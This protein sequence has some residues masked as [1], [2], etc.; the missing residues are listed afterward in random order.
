MAANR[1]FLRRR[2][3]LYLSG[4]A[5][6]L[7]ALF[8]FGCEEQVAPKRPTTPATGSIHITSTPD[9]A[10]VFFDDSDTG[11]V[12]PY[13]ISD[14]SAG[15]H[16]IRLTLS[17]HSDWGPKTVPVAAGQTTTVDATL[18][19]TTP[20]EPPNTRPTFPTP[21]TPQ[22]YTV[23]AAISPLALPQ[24]TGGNGSLSYS[25]M[26]P[27][28]GLSF[29][30]GSRVLSG[31]PTTAGAYAMSYKAT[32]SDGDQAELS[33][34]ITIEPRVERGLG[35]RR[36]DVNAYQS[37]Y[38]LRAPVASLP[39]SIDLTADFPLPRSQGRQASCVGW[40]VAFAVKSYHERVERGW[41]LTDD[42]HIMSPAYIYNQIKLPGGGAYYY[43]AFSLVRAQGVSSW[44]LMPYD[45]R[46]DQTQPSQAARAEAADYKIADWGGV[47]RTTHAEFVSEV[48]RHLV[49]K[50]PVP[51]AIPTC[52]DFDNLD[53]SNPVYD[54]SAGSC[55]GGHAIVIVGYDDAMSAFKIIN[56]WGSDWGIDG[57]GWIDYTASEQL[58]WEA[59]VLQD[60]SSVDEPPD[61]VTNPR[62]GDYANDVPTS[63]VLEWDQ[64]DRTTSFDVY[65]GTNEDLGAGDFQANVSQE[66]FTPHLAPSSTYFWRVDA[67]GRSGITPGPV[68]RFTTIDDEPVVP[69]RPM[70]LSPPNNAPS[71]ALDVT[72]RWASGGHTTSYDV[73]FGTNATLSA[74]DRQRTQFATTYSPGSLSPATRYYWRIDATN[75]VATTPGD[76]WAF[77]TVQGPP[78][79][80]VPVP[81]QT[82]TADTAI[83][84][85]T[86]PQASGGRSPLR[87]SLTPTVP[88]LRFDAAGRTLNGTPT[89]S[90]SYAMLY[91]V[92][93]ANGAT[94]SLRFTISVRHI[95]TPPTFDVGI[96]D[97]SYTADTA[98]STLRLPAATGGR[99]P[100]RY[101]LTPTV[102]GLHFDA[103]GR[104]LTGTPTASGSYAMLY[105]VTDA[106]GATASLRFTIS[107][108]HI[109]T[110]PTFDVGIPDQ[111]YTADTAIS[112]LRL[113]AATG[114]RS[115][116]RYG[117]TPTVPG[118]HF[119]ATGRTLTGTPTASGS[120]AMLYTVTDANGATASLR[121]TISV[122]HI[123]TPPTFDVGI[124]DQS[125]TADTAISTLRLPAATGGRSP[126]RYSLTP[127]VAGL[128]FNASGRTLSGTPTTAG[129]YAMTYTV[130]DANGATASLRFIV[131]VHKVGPRP[132]SAPAAPTLTPGTAPLR[133]EVTWTA[134][135]NN[136]AVITDY[137]VRYR[138]VGSANWID[139][140]HTGPTTNHTLGN[141]QAMTEGTSYEVQ[142]RATNSAGTGPWSPSAT[143]TPSSGTKRIAVINPDVNRILK[144]GYV[145]NYGGDSVNP[146]VVR[147]HWSLAHG[148]C[149]DQSGPLEPTNWYTGP[150]CLSGVGQQTDFIGQLLAAND[151]SVTYLEAANMPAIGSDDYDVVVVQDPL[152]T[153]LRKFTSATMDG[154]VPDLLEHVL[155][156][157][158]RTRLAN[159]HTAGGTLLLVGDAVRLLE[160]TRLGAGKTVSQHSTPHT[161]ST[162]DTARLTDK[163][164]FIRG[165]PFCGVD[166]NGSGTYT[167][168]SSSLVS[169]GSTLANLSL[170]NGND[171]RYLLV[172]SDTVYRPSDATSLLDVSITGSG[173]YVLRGDIC[174]PP[175]HTVTVSDTVSGF[176][177]YTTWKNRKVFYIGS[178][179]F[180]DFRFRHHGGAWH[181]GQYG[182]TSFDV[183]STGEKAILELVKQAVAE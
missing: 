167:V 153:N 33:F 74:S 155:S 10:R 79:F 90:G 53:E 68:W 140:G 62:P 8:L 7:L 133:I 159:Y 132:P 182:Q 177:G 92:T 91:T 121:F 43:D 127:T 151:Y 4:V 71:V 175:V 126:L 57:Y 17:G 137:D 130:T 110:P 148:S 80:P 28:P 13:T 61:P 171:S 169:N 60:V 154:S 22:S 181:A 12:T 34:T 161:V 100:L 30:P 5:G 81:D 37:S 42:A 99:S 172:W 55:R 58:I 97:Q 112:T 158:F 164:L 147:Y 59:Y 63:M 138:A 129:T 152:K 96:P 117:L 19:P 107:V 52:P 104:T 66:R 45:D 86:L 24:A 88:G 111:S 119:D 48:K 180:F 170:F 77:T 83:S 168:S 114:G 176:I 150:S 98:I 36:M 149:S 183:T 25:L 70:N 32:D 178:D 136:G 73:Y 141:K 156:S 106:N 105:T 157:Q 165:D 16:T 67:R 166:R 44:S 87:Y 6:A 39:R 85:L 115:P 145:T 163:W 11:R 162:A 3:L 54:T 29:D 23:G 128:R 47:S 173:D 102:P 122:R 49:A 116:L 103:T 31:T 134:P 139:N 51:I 143:G 120:Y 75:S 124:P 21:V 41:P 146:T 27:V 113:P 101:G 76:V 142:V 64:G 38:V 18:E 40:A 84:P 82:Y 50:T 144:S 131:T 14:V 69:G 1:N 35:L 78:E 46:D 56:S 123:S 94:A 108:R 160:S 118:L 2:A 9:G 125:Y 95:S 109:S 20:L 179:S 65:I 93:D 72:L 89:A 26:P 174:K 135:A 15:S